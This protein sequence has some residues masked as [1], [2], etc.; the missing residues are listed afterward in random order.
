MRFAVI[1]ATLIATAC[2]SPVSTAS[3][4][5]TSPLPLLLFGY[6]GAWLWVPDFTLVVVLLGVCLIAT[7]LLRL[8]GM[9]RTRSTSTTG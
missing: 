2:A 1:M 7:G 4:K 3:A 5:G 6:A 8:T 9:R